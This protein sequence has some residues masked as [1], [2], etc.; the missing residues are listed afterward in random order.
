MSLISQIHLP[1]NF[2]SR[3]SLRLPLTLCFLSRCSTTVSHLNFAIGDFLNRSVEGP[4]DGGSANLEY[5][6]NNVL[7]ASN[8]QAGKRCAQ[9][10]TL[11]F[12]SDLVKVNYDPLSIC[13]N[14]GSV[15]DSGVS[16]DIYAKG[17]G[18]GVIFPGMRT[19][20]ILHILVRFMPKRT[21][22]HK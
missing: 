10:K 6:D 9:P 12:M 15:G 5:A 19:T 17:Y 8:I 21:N 18:V 20:N 3:K 11:K 2:W 14:S 16:V 22:S 7:L 13:K 4:E 1:P